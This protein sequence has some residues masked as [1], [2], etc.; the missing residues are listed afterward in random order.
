MTSNLPLGCFLCSSSSLSC[1]CRRCSWGKVV[2]DELMSPLPMHHA[3]I[4]EKSIA[5]FLC[6]FILFFVFFY[7]MCVCLS[8]GL[9]L[10]KRFISASNTW[11]CPHKWG[12]KLLWHLVKIMWSPCHKHRWKISQRLINDIQWFLCLQ[13]L[14][15]CLER[16]SVAWQPSHLKCAIKNKGK[17]RKGKTESGK[18]GVELTEFNLLLLPLW[19][20]VSIHL[21]ITGVLMIWS[22]LGQ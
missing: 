11:F 4:C 5:C 13:M 12:W 15:H 3:G 17:I 8:S 9:G 16:W 6:S 10:K 22:W 18:L 7:L 20:K 1:S 21:V 14:K 2:E 19:V